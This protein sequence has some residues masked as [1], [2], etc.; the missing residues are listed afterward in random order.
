MSYSK[1]PEKVFFQGAKPVPLLCVVLL[2]AGIWLL[3]APEGIE[4]RAWQLF[5]IFVGVIAALIGKVLPMGGVSFV[6]L[7]TLIFTKTLSMKEAFS[8]F[9]HPIIWL[10][11]AAFLLSKS[12]IKTGLGMRIAYLFVAAIGRKTLGL[13]YGIA[14]TELMLAPAIPSITARAGGIVYPIVK[15][16][17][18][19]FNSTPEEHSQRKIGGFLILVAYYASLITSAM[20]ITAMAANPLIAGMLAD[21]GLTVTWGSWALAASVPGV[22]S[23]L[24]MPYVVFRLY[25]PE[26]KNTPQ[27]RD[28]AFEHL[29]KMGPLSF[30]EWQTLLVFIGLVFLWITGERWGMDSTLVALTGVAIFIL[31]GVL[32]WEDIKKEHDAWDTFIWF[33][34]LLMMATYLNELGLTKWISSY[35]QLLMGDMSSWTAWLMLVGMYFYTH[36]LFASNTAHVSS[37][38]ATFLSVGVALQVPPYLMAYSLAFCSS[39]FACITHYG[40]GSAP[41]L[42]GSEYVNVKTWWKM[43]FAM[44]LVFLFIWVGIGALWWKV[45]G[46]W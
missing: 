22:L 3:P 20:F 19:S 36:Y 37:M 26:I 28:I 8:G 31:T 15:A 33:S 4:P 46:L 45:L 2:A 39:L 6:A 17:A 30:Y 13:G 23:L 21:A 27:A 35:I 42:F 38:F 10:V 25:P 14:V 5:A 41:I 12:F 18:I 43:G 11:V 40:A 34:T 29:Q 32:T 1:K 9:S 7:T 44:S 24:L 16:L